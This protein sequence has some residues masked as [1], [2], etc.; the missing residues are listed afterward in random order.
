VLLAA[1]ARRIATSHEPPKRAWRFHRGHAP[2]FRKAG[3]RYESAR[4]PD[5]GEAHEM[6]EPAIATLGPHEKWM[7]R[8]QSRDSLAERAAGHARAV[9]RRGWN[10][11]GEWQGSDAQRGGVLAESR[12]SR[13]I[14]RA[15]ELTVVSRTASP[16]A[17]RVFGGAPPSPRRRLGAGK[18]GAQLAAPRICAIVQAVWSSECQSNL[19]LTGT[20]G[21]ARTHT[22]RRLRV[23]RCRVKGPLRAA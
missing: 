12:K 10:R 8:W 11:R 23:P 1:G 4:A 19:P 15:G 13:I 5:A 16:N 6:T 17:I 3:S 14:R 21:E 7:P 2:D 9:H 22:S 20:L 18:A